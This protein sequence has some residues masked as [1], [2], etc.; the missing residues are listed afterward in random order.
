VTDVDLISHF[1]PASGL[2]TVDRKSRARRW[3]DALDEGTH[4]ET[5]GD[6][7]VDPHQQNSGAA[8]DRPI[9]KLNK[10]S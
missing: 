10:R 2:P 4:F 9:S 5:F 8:D 7:S 6:V 1:D 3:L